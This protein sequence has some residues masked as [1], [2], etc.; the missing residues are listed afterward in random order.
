[1]DDAPGAVR[2]GSVMSANFEE[3]LAKLARLAVRFGVNVQPGQILY[4]TA[5]SAGLPLARL[6][7]EEAYKAGADHVLSFVLD[8]EITLAKY[9]HGSDASFDYAPGF[10][11]EALAEQ[12]KAGKLARLGI[13]GDTPSLLAAEDPTK[14]ARAAGANAA[15]NRPLMQAITTSTNWSIVAC[16]TPSTTTSRTR[17]TSRSARCSTA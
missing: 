6:V 12:A 13:Y 3:K 10:L 4:F 17:R 11:A 1:M 7:T 8:D 2:K 14:V 9:R 5:P 15:A 16:A